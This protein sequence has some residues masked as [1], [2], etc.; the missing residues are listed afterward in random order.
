MKTKNLLFFNIL[1]LMSFCRTALATHI[2]IIANNLTGLVGGASK[3]TH[4]ILL[5]AGSG[6]IIGALIKF[7]EH[8]QNP[9]EISLSKPITLLLFGV[10]LIGLAIVT[11]IV[12]Q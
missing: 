5:V 1:L 6:L 10:A 9:E 8:R 11:M 4:F 7:H 12:E 2:G 3:I